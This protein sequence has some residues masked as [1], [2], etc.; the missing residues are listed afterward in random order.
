MYACIINFNNANCFAGAYQA[1]GAVTACNDP[2]LLLRLSR[3]ELFMTV[4]NYAQ[5]GD[6]N[7]KKMWLGESDGMNYSAASL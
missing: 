5:L 1:P 3:H 2:R 7:Q 4:I 6:N